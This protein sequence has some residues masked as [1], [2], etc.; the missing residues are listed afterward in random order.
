MKPIPPQKII[1]AVSL[2]LLCSGITWLRDYYISVMRIPVVPAHYFIVAFG[3]VEVIVGA[4]FWTQRRWFLSAATV[5]CWGKAIF[6][7]G[8]FGY[9][10]LMIPPLRT[11]V[12]FHLVSVMHFLLAAGCISSLRRSD[13]RHAYFLRA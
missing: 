7:V 11:S 2:F 10:L 3:I 8:A 9:T 6:A 12:W 13:V 1:G 4:G 5:L